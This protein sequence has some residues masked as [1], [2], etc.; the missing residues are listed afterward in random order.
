MWWCCP[1]WNNSVTAY[2]CSLNTLLSTSL[3]PIDSRVLI[4]GST[5]KYFW[6]PSFIFFCMWF[7]LNGPKKTHSKTCKYMCRNNVWF[8]LHQP[9]EKNE[10]LPTAFGVNS[11]DQSSLETEI[12]DALADEANLVPYKDV[13]FAQ[14]GFSLKRGTIQLY[15]KSSFSNDQRASNRRLLFEYEF[16]ETKVCVLRDWFL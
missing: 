12:M 11:A 7:L 10:T 4:K 14:L 16:T 2:T 15:S 8:L 13:V 1:K 6:F 3:P 5:A 9:E